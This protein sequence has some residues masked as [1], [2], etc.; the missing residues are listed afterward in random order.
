MKRNIT[1]PERIERARALR[2]QGYTCSQC[3]YMAF[4]DIHGLAPDMAAAVSCGLG[5]GIGGQH[6]VCGT[7]SAM[8]LVAGALRYTGPA[9]KLSVYDLVK[10]CSREF[11]GRNGSIVCAEL[12]ADTPRRKPC[13]AYIEDAVTLLHG[14][15]S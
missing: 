4:D 15:L 3:V 11:S 10:E 8:S 7:V 6:Q 1:L 12:L 2:K 9:S 13:M 5:G 14:K